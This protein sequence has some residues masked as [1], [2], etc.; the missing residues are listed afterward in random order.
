MKKFLLLIATSFQLMGTISWAFAEPYDLYDRT[1]KR[2]VVQV[3]LPDK[4]A[5]FEEVTVDESIIPEDAY[6]EELRSLFHAAHQRE[7]II[8][9]TSPTPHALR[10]WMTPQ[11]ATGYPNHWIMLSLSENA[12]GLYSRSSPTANIIGTTKSGQPAFMAET[13]ANPEAVLALSVAYQPE[14]VS[15]RHEF[16]F[17]L[18]KDVPSD[19]FSTWHQPFSEEVEPDETNTWW[20]L[21]HGKPAEQYPVNSKSHPVMRFRL[22]SMDDALTMDRKH[23]RAITAAQLQHVVDN[24][25]DQTYPFF[26]PPQDEE[27]PACL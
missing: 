26:L 12:K 11:D 4:T 15:N 22:M 9:R 25:S 21:A 13:H 27:I 16:W 10:V 14:G 1:S 6:A 24:P 17:S 3:C 19:R 5:S 8:D 2:V 20:R 7:L 23:R 18:P